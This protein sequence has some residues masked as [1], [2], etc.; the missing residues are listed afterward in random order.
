MAW[1][2]VVL[3]MLIVCAAGCAGARCD[4][5]AQCLSNNCHYGECD[6][7]LVNVI[8]DA[9]EEDEDSLYDEEPVYDPPPYEPPPEC[10]PFACLNLHEDDCERSGCWLT[11]LGCGE[12]DDLDCFIRSTVECAPECPARF[13]CHGTPKICDEL[14]RDACRN[15]P[16]CRVRNEH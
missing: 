14:D 2:K 8:D 16:A 7:P 6:S 9:T 15:E 5:D 13:L 10:E 12:P 1:L 3:S 11:R 4:Q